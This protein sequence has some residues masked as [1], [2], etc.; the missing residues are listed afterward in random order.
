MGAIHTEQA[1]AYHRPDLIRLVKRAYSTVVYTEHERQ[2]L[3]NHHDVAPERLSLIG[4]GIEVQKPLPR[5][6]AFREAH[7]IPPEAL[8]IS[9]VGAHARQKGIE[10][11]IEVLPRLLDLHGEAWLVI[12]G[13]ETEY[14]AD[15]QRL[16]AAIPDLARA[17]V[18]FF[19]DISDSLKAEILVD[20]DVF[21]SPSREES[22]GITIIEAWAYEKPVVVG[23]SPGQRDVVEDGR[24]GLVVEYGNRQHLLDALGLLLGNKTLRAQLGRAGKEQVAARYDMSR[25][26]AQYHALFTEAVESGAKATTD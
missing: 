8:V 1:W 9:Y 7:G 20:C 16:I 18:L 17:R 3:I 6:G 10:A 24:L 5:S 22:F 19:S 12:A 25:I 4:H 2:W 23:N 11:L 13:A 15:L 26:V 14:S 21:A